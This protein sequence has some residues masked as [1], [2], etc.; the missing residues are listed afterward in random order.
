M[1]CRDIGDGLNIW[2]IEVIIVSGN[3]RDINQV[4]RL[5]IRGSE[6][7]VRRASVPDIPA[8]IYREFH[9]VG[10]AANILGPRRLA[11]RQ[12]AELIEVH[13]PRSYGLKIRIQEGRVTL[14]INVIA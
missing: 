2:Q 8:R 1:K 9:E 13:G 12:S 3:P 6:V 10:E 14:L 5:R 7:G 4:K 11:A